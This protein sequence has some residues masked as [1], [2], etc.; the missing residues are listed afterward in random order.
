[1]EGEWGPT[2]TGSSVAVHPLHFHI[3]YLYS[4]SCMVEKKVVIGI[5]WLIYNILV[6]F[7]AK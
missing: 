3:A 2:D 7:L 1:M 6:T 5:S 4:G